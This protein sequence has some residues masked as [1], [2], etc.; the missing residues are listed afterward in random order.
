VRRGG[1]LY[2]RLLE[3]FDIIWQDVTL[4]RAVESTD[5]ED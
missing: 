1:E 4:S 2:R 5:L 3:H